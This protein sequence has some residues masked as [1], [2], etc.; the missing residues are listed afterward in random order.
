[1]SA[2]RAGANDAHDGDERV[3]VASKRTINLLSNR[4]DKRAKNDTDR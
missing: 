4:T 3:N 1:M 2:G